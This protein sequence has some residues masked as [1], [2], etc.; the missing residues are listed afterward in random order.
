MAL[1]AEDSE[2]VL[3]G[4]TLEVYR[5]LLRQSKPMGVREIQRAL[6]LSSPSVATYHLAKLEEIGLLKRENGAY[7]VSKFLLEYSIKISRFLI[8]R[9]LFYAIFAIVVLLVEL[10]LMRPSVVTREYVFSLVATAVF[11]VVF[12]YETIKT[13]RRGTL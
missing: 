10:S 11:V 7:T 9:Y 3:K 2:K 13:W 4:T 12:F 8:P 1:A 6:D 5:F